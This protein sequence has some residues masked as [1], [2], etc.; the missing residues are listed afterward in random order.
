MGR[1]TCWKMAMNSASPILKTKLL[2][3]GNIRWKSSR[4]EAYP[5]VVLLLGQY[6][7]EEDT[8]SDLLVTYFRLKFI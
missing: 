2:G 4:Q 7:K 8:R 3:S 6:I 1:M 5:C